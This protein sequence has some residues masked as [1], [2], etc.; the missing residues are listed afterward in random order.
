MKTTLVIK[1][2]PQA[3]KQK[4]W[5]DKSGIIKCALKS[6]PEKGKAN[7]ELVTIISKLLGIPKNTVALV[8]GETDRTKTIVIDAPFASH[9]VLAKLGIELELLG[10]EWCLL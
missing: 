4:L 7:A 3:G 5:L 2:I 6:A 10:V 9:Q 8:R 1:V